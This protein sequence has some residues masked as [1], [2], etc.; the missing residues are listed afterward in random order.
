MLS[1]SW[2]QRGCISRG[3]AKWCYYNAGKKINL[4]CGLQF[5]SW[6]GKY[7]FKW[8][9]CSPSMWYTDSMFNINN[10]CIWLACV[11]IMWWCGVVLR[12]YQVWACLIPHQF[13]PSLR[14]NAYCLCR[15]SQVNVSKTFKL[16]VSPNLFHCWHILNMR[17]S[18]SDEPLK[19]LVALYL[20]GL[21]SS[22]SKSCAINC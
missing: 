18:M 17:N 16:P 14:S 13:K 12:F 5:I 19:A 4:F 7:Q 1:L 21:A 10:Y 8:W 3:G 22:L 11:V 9:L 20:K 6:L 2:K 15:S